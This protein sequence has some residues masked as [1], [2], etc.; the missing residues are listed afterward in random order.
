[1]ASKLSAA[2][3]ASWSGVRATIAHADRAN[4]LIDAV[5]GASG[6][7][8]V[9]APRTTTLNARKL[10][11]AFARQSKGTVVVDAGAVA[12]LTT[13]GRSLLPAGIIDVSGGFAAGDAI[14]VVG[15]DGMR[16]AK[17]LTRHATQALQEAAGRQSVDLDSELAGAAIHRDD[18]VILV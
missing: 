18:L 4:V 12:A 8:T 10:W 5:S 9:M 16:V 6:V 7:G 2:R 13:R 3:I 14:D 11:I 17:G 15:P 1:M